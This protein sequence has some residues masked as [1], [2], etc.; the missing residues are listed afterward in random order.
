MELG[1]GKSHLSSSVS[2]SM[3]VTS[4][5]SACFER[6]DKMDEMVKVMVPI[7]TGEGRSA[8]CR[9]NPQQTDLFRIRRR[10]ASV[11]ER[12]RHQDLVLHRITISVASQRRPPRTCSRSPS[13]PF[14]RAIRKHNARP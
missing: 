13:S 9:T 7:S 8:H 6:H 2:A 11:V 4:P 14:L 10:P 12:L 1:G 3:P 5:K